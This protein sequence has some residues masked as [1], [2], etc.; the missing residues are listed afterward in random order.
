M[1]L[2]VFGLAACAHTP[3]DP[4]YLMPDVRDRAPVMVSSST[5]V[6][7]GYDDHVVV[8]VDLD[9]LREQQGYDRVNDT[10]VL[11]RGPLVSNRY[12]SRRAQSPYPVSSGSGPTG[13]PSS[14]SSVSSINR[15]A[16]TAGGSRQFR[17]RR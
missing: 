13:T 4:A 7:D 10:R 6:P 5:N 3:S 2:A 15:N 11:R 16:P 1:A 12:H 8:S 9:A 14:T 17:D